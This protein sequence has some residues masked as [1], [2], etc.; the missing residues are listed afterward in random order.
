MLTRDKI[1]EYI[2]LTK[3][4][5]EAVEDLTMEYLKGWYSIN[6]WN[7]VVEHQIQ[8]VEFNLEKNELD[9]YIRSSYHIYGWDDDHERYLIPLD[10]LFMEKEEW[11]K[12][13]NEKFKE[14]QKQF[15]QLKEEA[16]KKDRDDEEKRLRTQYE[17]LKK[18]FEG[19]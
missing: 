6:N 1:K 19:E 8:D 13:L 10:Y 18:M 15:Q 5:S 7:R 2:E 11:M 16:E 9:V 14:E 3:E 4:V 12:L 17:K